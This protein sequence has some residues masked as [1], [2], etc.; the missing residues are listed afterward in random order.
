MQK[1]KATK[2]QQGDVLIESVAAIP[3]GAQAVPHKTLREGEATGHAHRAVAEDA[4]LFIV[5]DNLYLRAPS[6][7]EVVHE[8]HN[9]VTLPPGDYRIDG[10]REYDHFAEE[11]RYVAD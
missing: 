1:Q 5:G 8:E 6:G 7:T 4:Q 3:E 2:I 11:A 9:A 10:V